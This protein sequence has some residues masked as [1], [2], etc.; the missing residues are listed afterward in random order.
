MATPILI[1][2]AGGHGRPVAD[3]VRSEGR[4]AIVGL[5]D[6][7]K[8]KGSVCFG[9][10]VL[11]PE[12]EL[13]AICDATGVRQGIVAIGDNWQRRAM[14][15]RVRQAVDGFVFVTVVHPA[16][17]VAV[18]VAMGPGTVVMPGVVLVSGCRLGDGCI[19]NTG[20]SLDHDG[21]MADYASLGPGATAGGN[22]R[23]GVCSAIGLGANLIQRVC[24]GDHTV[25]GAGALVLRD[26]PGGVVAYGTPCRVV[27]SRQ[28]DEPYL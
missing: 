25:V 10:E 17:V 24:V 27:R 13:P 11:G 20:A 18:D 1:I 2:G 3:V 9:H 5:V 26:V 22:V 23:V 12:R 19:V 28:P 15:E 21:T 14:A 6:S 8:A 7:V 16:A 4:Y